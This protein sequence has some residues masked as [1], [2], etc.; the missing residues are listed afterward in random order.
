MLTREAVARTGIDGGFSAVYPV[1]RAMED[2]GRIRRGYFVD[3][4]G[5]A[6]FALAGALD[7]LRA[8][9]D[10]A[11]PPA[12]GAVHLLAAADPANPYGAALPWPRR[13]EDRPA[14]AT[15]ARPGVRRAG[16]RDR[17]ALPGAG[18]FATLQVL[19][20]AD[21]PEVAVAAARALSLA[22]R[23]RPVPRAGRSARS[24]ATTWRPRRFRATLL[25]AGF[26]GRLP[27]PPAPCRSTGES[28][29]RR[30]VASAEC[31]KATR[32][33]GPRPGLRPY[34]VGRTGHRRPGWR[35]RTRS[36]RSS[37]SSGARS[38]AVE[39]LGKNLLIRFDNGLE[40][41]THLRMNGSWHRYRPG[42]ALAPAAGPRAAGASR[43]PGAVAVC[44][45]APVVELLEQRAEALH[46][47]LG[48]LGPDLLAPAFDAAEAVRRL[49]DPSRAGDADRRGARRPARPGRD[50]QRLQE[51]GAV[52]RAGRR[53]SRRGG[54][55]RRRRPRP[56]R[57]DRPAAAA[58][59]NADRA[60]GRSG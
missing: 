45:D 47:S 23:R 37:G 5:A 32:S 29:R 24:T 27:R 44:F 2:A 10:A 9:R 36:R 8:V 20:A 43:S 50:R 60:A 22:R 30:P 26:V 3:G 34:L 33:S 53:R 35:S 7:R 57:R 31:P 55:A 18:W 14:A 11:D 16:R 1:L 17:G 19:P 42:R 51:R 52:D 54:R 59:S 49:R 15:S 6:Q 40:I 28:R 13:G 21:D 56:A 46:P 39:A 25:E 38:R 4:L 48:R 41:R 58:G 12:T